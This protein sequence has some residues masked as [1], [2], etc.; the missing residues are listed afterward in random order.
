MAVEG[1]GVAPCSRD[2]IEYNPTEESAMEVGMESKTAKKHTD[3]TVVVVEWGGLTAGA[4]GPPAV[5]A[6]LVC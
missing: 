1:A 5:F 4:Y 3:L 6:L 2:V